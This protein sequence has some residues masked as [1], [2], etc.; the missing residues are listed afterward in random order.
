MFYKGSESESAA[1]LIASTTGTAVT[2]M[3]LV[4]TGSTG[5][6]VDSFW[7]VATVGVIAGTGSAV[8]A[9]WLSRR[10]GLHKRLLSVPMAAAV[11][12]LALAAIWIAG[13]ITNAVGPR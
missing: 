12:A 13:Y 2:L 10:L 1:A 4:V 11:F 3:V 9:W 6:L 7:T 5:A 8:A